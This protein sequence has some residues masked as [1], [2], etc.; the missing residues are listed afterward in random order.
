MRC[1]QYILSILVAKVISFDKGVLKPQGCQ[2][3]DGGLEPMGYSFWLP[4]DSS[5][6]P[7][8]NTVVEFS[9]GDCGFVINGEAEAVKT[10]VES[11]EYDGTGYLVKTGKC[12]GAMM[13]TVG[14]DTDP[15]N[16]KSDDVVIYHV[17]FLQPD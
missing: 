11:V 1:C 12:S 3:W 15:N 13:F 16:G 10:D 9:M 6:Y 5:T 8:A 7:A 14:Y 2:L 17:H 4:W